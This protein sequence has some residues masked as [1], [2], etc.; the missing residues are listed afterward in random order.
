MNQRIKHVWEGSI[1]LRMR[2]AMIW[3]FVCAVTTIVAEISAY[4][5]IQNIAIRRPHLALTM[6]PMIK[7]DKR[8]QYLPLDIWTLSVLTNCESYKG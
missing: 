1:Q 6:L 3:P 5:L 4:M 7:P 2:P 8:Y